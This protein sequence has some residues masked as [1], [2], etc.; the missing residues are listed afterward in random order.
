M[1]TAAA[2]RALKLAREVQELFKQADLEGRPLSAQERTYAQGLLDQAEEIGGV[3]RQFHELGKSLGAPGWSANVGGGAAFSGGDP[4][5]RFVGSEGFKSITGG[6]RGQTFSTGPVDLGSPHTMFKGTLLELGG[7]G[8]DA[9]V[10]TP[11]VVP[12]VFNMLSQPLSIEAALLSG[13]ANTASLRYITQGTATSG[14]GGV[15]EGSA[16][17]EST[18]GFDYVDESVKKV[19]TFLPISEEALDDAPAIQTF[20][21]GELLRFVNIEVE[22]E[23]F[24]GVAGG[25]EVQGLLVSRGVPV[26]TS[27]GTATDG[28][29]GRQLFMA[30]NSMRG[31]AFIELEWCIMSVSDY[32]TLRLLEDDNGQL[33]GGGP[34]VG[35]YGAGSPVGASGQVT[36]QTDTV[37]GKPTFVT[38]ALGAGTALLGTRS[39][40][41]VM[42]RG[43]ATVEASNSHSDFFQ[44][45]LVAIRAE[46]RLALC[47]YRPAGFCE[48]RLAT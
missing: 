12:G 15:A 13:Q 9:F 26:W 36:G 1:S 7:G 19:A 39:S 31:S 14:A 11:Q 25:P 3:A 47:C 33:Y 4:G 30:M 40:A 48:V 24:Y 8:A 20:I 17:P 10:A 37:W 6:R 23:L 5:A 2:P 29:I 41:Q 42:N 45:N 35:A 32:E 27:A 38:T 18:L 21:N 28:H 43:G 44:L 46:R 22:R 16:K 34:F